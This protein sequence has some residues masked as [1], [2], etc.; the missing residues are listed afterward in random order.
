MNGVLQYRSK[1]WYQQRMKK[2]ESDH[3]LKSPQPNCEESE[4]PVY[5]F[6][7]PYDWKNEWKLY[8]DE[9]RRI[10]KEQDLQNL[11]H[12]EKRIT[13]HVIKEHGLYVFRSKTYYALDHKTSIWYGWKNGIPP[14][15]IGHISNLRYIPSVENTSKGIKC[16]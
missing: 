7:K 3:K 16:E 10:T 15:T 5:D 8:R 9:V 12:Y 11:E 14:E 4:T 1:E 13:K 6:P 2:I